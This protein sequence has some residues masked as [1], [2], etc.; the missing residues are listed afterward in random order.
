MLL[1]HNTVFS[2][3]QLK[4]R[5]SS[6]LPSTNA[7]HIGLVVAKLWY[8]FPRWQDGDTIELIVFRVQNFVSA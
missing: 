4:L 6:F 3:K 1:F 2:D 7:R 8:C 5:F